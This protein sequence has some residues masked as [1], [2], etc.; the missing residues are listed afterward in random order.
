MSESEHCGSSTPY[1]LYLV[2]LQEFVNFSISNVVSI[3][4]ECFF[5][6][7]MPLILRQPEVPFLGIRG[8]IKLEYQILDLSEIKRLVNDMHIVHYNQ[9]I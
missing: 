6:S 8:D 3:R 5:H 7:Q 1:I 2:V 4:I 9:Q